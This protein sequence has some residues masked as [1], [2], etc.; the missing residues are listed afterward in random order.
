MRRLA[1]VV[2]TGLVFAAGVACAQE[3][4]D[5]E[6]AKKDLESAKASARPRKIHLWT[7]RLKRSTRPA[8]TASAR[9]TTG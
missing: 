7:P 1:L 9:T 3:H 5:M 6:A 2:A 8:L 4:P